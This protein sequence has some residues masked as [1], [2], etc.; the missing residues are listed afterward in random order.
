MGC[1]FPLGCSAFVAREADAEVGLS[2]APYPWRFLILNPC[3][4]IFSFLIRDRFHP[5]F[6][7]GFTSTRPLAHTAILEPL[8]C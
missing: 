3:F 8:G 5:L 7:P 4:S 1:S 2:G 6:P